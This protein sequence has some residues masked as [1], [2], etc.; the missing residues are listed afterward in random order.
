M[1]ITYTQCK[2]LIDNGYNLRDIVE[3]LR[4]QPDWLYLNGSPLEI[5]DIQ[6]ISQGGCASGAHMDAVTYHKAVQTMSEYGDDVLDFIENSG[7]GTK[8]KLNP[9]SQ[10]W[11]GFCC[12]VLSMAVELWCRQF[13]LDNVDW[14]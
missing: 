9:E 5:Y 11:G 2:Q 8:F 13:D 7:I 6:A 4:D 14:D 12:D 3:E 1:N 10:S